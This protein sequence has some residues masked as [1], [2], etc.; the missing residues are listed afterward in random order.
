MKGDIIPR[1]DEKVTHIRIGEEQ[2]EILE[3]LKYENETN[4]EILT[5]ILDDY[6]YKGVR[7]KITEIILELQL[8]TNHYIHQDFYHTL[9]LLK[10][11]ILKAKSSENQFI[12]ADI[13]EKISESLEKI[14]S[15]DFNNKYKKEQ[16]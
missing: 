7:R 15:Y 11:V 5:R 9:E 12:R 13:C 8:I 1:K 2:K 6:Y 14:I 10:A 3:S 16:W 4:R